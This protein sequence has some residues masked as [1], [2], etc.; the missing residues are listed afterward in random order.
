MSIIPFLLLAAL[1]A[2]CA[3]SGPP[4]PP[5]P[6]RLAPAVALD[7]ARLG[8]G[9]SFIGNVKPDRETDL[10]FKVPGIVELIGPENGAD[11]EQGAAVRQGEV[12]A[13]LK[14]ADFINAVNQARARAELDAKQF[15]R[16]RTLLAQGATTQ[17]A[18][19]V[20]DANK[21]ASEAALAQAEQALTDS[22]LRAPYDGVIVMRWVNKDET[23]TPGKPVLRLG[24]VRQMSVQLGVPD[25]VVSRVRV[26]QPAALTVPALPERDFVGQVSEVGVAAEEGTRLFKVVVKIPNPGGRL[27]SGM[28]A[29]VVLGEDRAASARAVVVPLS[30]LVTTAD[31]A[32]A[33]FVVG[34]DGTARERRVKTDDIV[35]SSIVITDGLRAGETVVVVGA[36]LLYD[37][38][39]V[40]GL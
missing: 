17:Q 31:G 6:V 8:T 2:G 13:R 22:T 37:G 21:R 18:F 23:V 24:D 5:L 36:G 9:S 38:A 25:V 29:S 33:V 27:K 30:A 11:W 35:A 26:G 1:A 12:L 14:Q 16:A 40:R 39:P 28:T 32:L 15:E 3:K 34:P 4:A 19:D 20:A 7:A 10:S